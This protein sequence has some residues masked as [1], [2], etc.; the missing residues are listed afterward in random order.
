MIFGILISDGLK[1]VL[2]K[3]NKYPITFIIVSYIETE[4]F[5]ARCADRMEYLR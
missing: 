1:T 4:W 2:I 5:V 3:S